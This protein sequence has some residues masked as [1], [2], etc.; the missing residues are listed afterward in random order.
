MDEEEV[1]TQAQNATIRA[2]SALKKQWGDIII[3]EEFDQ[4]LSWDIIVSSITLFSIVSNLYCSWSCEITEQIFILIFVI[5]YVESQINLRFYES[6]V[7]RVNGSIL[8]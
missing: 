8:L 5:L 1:I 3:P 4:F 2:W 6:K 7:E